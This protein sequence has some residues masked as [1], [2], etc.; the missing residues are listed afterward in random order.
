MRYLLPILMLVLIIGCPK[1]VD[2]LDPI[3]CDAGSH[4]CG[5]DSQ[6]CCLDTTSHDFSWRLDTFGTA[7]GNLYDAVI[8]HEH[9]IWVAGRIRVEEVDSTGEN[10]QLVWYNAMHWDGSDWSLH[11]AYD[12]TLLKDVF[13]FAS[14]DVWF[15]NGKNVIHFDGTSFERLWSAGYGQVNQVTTIW[16]ASPNDIY[17]GGKDG[18]I[19]H[20]DGANFDRIQT[21]LES[22]FSAITGTSGGGDVF[23]LGSPLTWPGS[24]VVLH[25]SNTFN[26]WRMIEYPLQALLG[27]DLP[28]VHSFAV[29]GN[30]L[31]ISKNLELWK[32]NFNSRISRLYADID[33]IYE[34]YNF[35]KAESEA[36]IFYGGAKFDYLHYNG[37]GYKYVNEIQQNYNSISMNGGDFKG[38]MVVMVG[39]YDQLYWP[40]SPLVAF[41]H[42]H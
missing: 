12:N 24:D 36:D 25:T 16:G 26:S 15:V 2:E 10:T 23:V 22:R 27:Y 39:G 6:S 9:D 5:P 4:P 30:N 20:F 32:Y 33:H 8:I 41:G 40:G 7:E 42:R 13:A 3:I 18:H 21:G 11:I 34:K 19:L 31:Y 14:D 35:I 37:S 38:D 29:V 28:D 1:P 17:F